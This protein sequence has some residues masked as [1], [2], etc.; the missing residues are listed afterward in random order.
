MPQRSMTVRALSGWTSVEFRSDFKATPSIAEMQV[1]VL[2]CVTCTCGHKYNSFHQ[3]LL[4]DQMES[5]PAKSI[6]R[7]KAKI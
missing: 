3:V 1:S 6:I 7:Y 2:I 5:P 4:K